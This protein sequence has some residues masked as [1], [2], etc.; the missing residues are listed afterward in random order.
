MKWLHPKNKA[1]K[2][3]SKYGFTL[4]ELLVVITILSVLL[5]AGVTV[6]NFLIKDNRDQQRLRELTTIKQ[7]LELYRN[8]AQSYPPSLTFN[9]PATGSLQN[10][11]KTYLDTIPNDPLC[12]KG[13]HYAYQALPKVPSAC[14]GNKC[15][16]FVLCA[17]K[18]GRGTYNPVTEC[19][20]LDCFGT[21]K[22][23][24]ELTS[25]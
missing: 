10:G 9:C 22:C 16:D 13:R 5:A 25:N 15:Q 1:K 14:A 6:M 21:T 3:L 17:L 11:S 18:Q 2:R 19:A 23:D 12:N 8:D 4:V 20:N 24:L 7:A